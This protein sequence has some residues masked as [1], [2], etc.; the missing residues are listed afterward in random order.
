MEDNR[1]E[2]VQSAQKAPAQQQERRRRTKKSK[3]ARLLQ[4]RLLVLAAALIVFFL[5]FS[6]G[7]MSRGSSVKVNEQTVT[8]QLGALTD[9]SKTSYH[10]TN[11]ERFENIEDFYGWDASDYSSFT[12]S[13]SGTV[14][15]AVD[16]SGV[17]VS[18]KGKNI[19][20]TLP[21]P[22]ATAPEIQEDSVSVLKDGK[23][24][25]IQL[26]DFAGF[27]KDQKSVIEAKTTA[28]GLLFDASDKAKA[29]A[30]SLIEAMTG[31]SD[32]YTISIK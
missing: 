18:V 9:L 5:C 31:N 13:Y 27:S 26:T 23:F 19:T 3:R 29:A 7:A 11:V 25:T 14:T 4:R 1:I 20:V 6:L 10:F 30:K 22:S 16:A 8:A 17:K 12:L 2:T 24:D 15:A 28:D 32:K 21:E